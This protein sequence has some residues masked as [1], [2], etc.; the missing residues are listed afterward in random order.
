MA[1]AGRP[2]AHDAELARPAVRA[3]AGG[4]ACAPGQAARG[5]AARHVRRAGVDRRRPVSYDECRAAGFAGAAVRLVLCRAERAYVCHAPRQA[6]RLLLQPRRE[7]LAG[8]G[9][10]AHALSPALLRGD[11]ER[12]AAGQ[13]FRLH[14]R[15]EHPDEGC[16]GVRGDVS[17]DR[18][19]ADADAGHAGALSDR[20]IL[21]LHRRR[22]PSRTPARDS[23]P[24][25][26]AAGGGSDD[27]GE[28]DGGGGRHPPAVHRAAPA[29]LEAAGRGGV[30]S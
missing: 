13:R 4:R 18:L 8:G 22:F 27:R 15:A 1:A 28:H 9:R 20:A 24:A 3:L 17:A 7:Q 30:G 26:A 11:D 5:F 16:R 19:D 14:E 21:P 6:R 25:V 2:V 10:R 29:L 12:G 23:S